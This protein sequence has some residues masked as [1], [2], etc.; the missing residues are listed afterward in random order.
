ML[1]MSVTHNFKTLTSGK[2]NTKGKILQK[3]FQTQQIPFF[4]MYVLEVKQILGSFWK[5]VLCLA[6]K[7]L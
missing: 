2:K 5:T 6:G 3:E 7:Y 1:L 4:N